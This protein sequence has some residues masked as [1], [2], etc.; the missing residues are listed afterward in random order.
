[1]ILDQDL[2]LFNKFINLQIERSLQYVL[3]I[4]KED[5]KKL[6]YFDG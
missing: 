3:S 5:K 1:M 4:Y 2:W 6:I